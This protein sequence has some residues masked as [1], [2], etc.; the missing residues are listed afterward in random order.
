VNSNLWLLRA[1]LLANAALFAWCTVAN[2][3]FEPGFN[4]WLFLAGLFAGMGMGA[5]YSQIKLLQ[6]GIT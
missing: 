3:Y 4:L 6:L 1:N 2:F 5:T